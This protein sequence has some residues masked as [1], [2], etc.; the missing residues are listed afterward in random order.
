MYRLQESDL[1]LS[2]FAVF[3]LVAYV[4]PFHDSMGYGVFPARIS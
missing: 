1:H 2:V 3:D 4:S